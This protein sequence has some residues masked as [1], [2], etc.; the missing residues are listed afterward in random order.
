MNINEKIGEIAVI[1]LR[2]RDQ[3]KLYH[4]TTTSYSRHKASDKLVETITEQM[5]RFIETIQGSRNSRLKLT[6]K[7][8]VLKF[9]NTTDDSIIR[10]LENFKLWLIEGLPL[11][12]ENFDKDLRNIRD[13]ILSSVNQTLYLFSLQ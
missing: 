11:Y 8:R 4:W 13:E 6:D 1:F 5:D 9:F 2:F 7:N 3:L 10:V 12:L